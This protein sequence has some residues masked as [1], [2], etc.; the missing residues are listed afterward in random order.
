[1]GK[2]VI[3]PI[4]SVGY[5]WKERLIVH[6]KRETPI[7]L[8]CLRI[9]DRALWWRNPTTPFICFTIGIRGIGLVIWLVIVAIILVPF[10][11]C[12][13]TTMWRLLGRFVEGLDVGTPV[14]IPPPIGV[15]GGITLLVFTPIFF[16]FIPVPIIIYVHGRRSRI[17]WIHCMYPAEYKPVVPSWRCRP[18]S[19]LCGEG[20]EMF[21]SSTNVTRRIV[22]GLL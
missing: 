16:I 14:H 19:P 9:P 13:T 2:I 8:L 7:W 17:R 22:T 11:R 5:W 10:W 1:M 12:N 15:R 21:C 18:R 4:G 6:S 3:V 20:V